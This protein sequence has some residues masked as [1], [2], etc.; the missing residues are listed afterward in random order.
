M[1]ISPYDMLVCAQLLVGELDCKIWRRSVSKEQLCL[2]LGSA[3]LAGPYENANWTNFSSTPTPEA[4]F[5][6][7]ILNTTIQPKTKILMHSYSQRLLYLQPEPVI[8]SFSWSVQGIIRPCC[9]SFRRLTNQCDVSH[10]V[11]EGPWSPHIPLCLKT[12]SIE[13]LEWGSFFSLRAPLPSRQA[14][15][16]VCCQLPVV[17]GFRSKSGH[18]RECQFH[19]CI[20]D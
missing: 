9:V 10:K 4:A 19:L 2:G 14:A 1:H 20:V 6:R 17:G 18:S 11:S 16:S 15:S 13:W 5:C 3:R 8:A 7:K 12:V